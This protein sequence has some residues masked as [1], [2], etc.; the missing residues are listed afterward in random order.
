VFLGNVNLG[1]L[2]TSG[3][4]VDLKWRGPASSLGRF[5]FGLNGTYVTTYKLDFGT[6]QFSSGLGNNQVNGPVPRWR[7]YASV[8]WSNGPW[9][10][11]LAQTFQLGY[12]ECN[13]LTV[14]PETGICNGTRRVGDYSVI[15]IQGQ[16]TGFKSTTVVLGVKNLFDRDPPFTQ[17]GSGFSGGYD[18]IYAD[19]RGVTYYANL[20]FAFK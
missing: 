12:S 11:T 8:T 16:Y 4:D 13:Q 3:F 18:P 6:D 14:D 15:D 20:T 19:P 9:S 2:R 5:S 17:S 1:D 7:H 10:A